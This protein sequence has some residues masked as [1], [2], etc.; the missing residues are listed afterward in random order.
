MMPMLSIPTGSRPASEI[1]L[2]TTVPE[3]GAAGPRP[4]TGPMAQRH[5]P[6][7]GAGKSRPAP[8]RQG[9]VPPG[10][11]PVGSRTSGVISRR[12]AVSRFMAAAAR[13]RSLSARAPAKIHGCRPRFDARR[14]GKSPARNLANPLPVDIP[15]I[16]GEC[17]NRPPGAVGPGPHGRKAPRAPGDPRGARSWSP[18]ASA[19][20]GRR[21]KPR[22]AGPACH[23]GRR[24]RPIRCHGP[25]QPSGPGRP[26]RRPR[27]FPWPGKRPPPAPRPRCWNRPGRFWAAKPSRYEFPPRRPGNGAATANISPMG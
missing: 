5:P 7:A 3:P 17:R 10:R 8:G 11:C 21:R 22:P 19:R 4:Q 16:R 20:H 26:G 15:S 24:Q 9:L 2:K 23:R 18:P 27:L 6:P 1:L 25:G 14:P 13:S 12:R